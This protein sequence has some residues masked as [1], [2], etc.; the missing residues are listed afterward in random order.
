MIETQE[1]LH[2]SEV[3]KLLRVSTRRVRMIPAAELPFVQ[4]EVKGR[5]AYFSQDVAAY[6]ERRTVRA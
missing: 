2:A 5:R 1:L 4:L 6:V 3:A